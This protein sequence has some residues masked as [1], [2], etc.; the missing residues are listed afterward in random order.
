MRKLMMAA[1]GLMMAMSANAQY[2]NDSKTPFEEGKMYVNAA[3]SSM[4]LSYSKAE[5][6]N[7]GINGKVG[8]FI[9]D[10]LMGV[11]VAGLTS[12]GSGDRTTLQLGAG[13][14][15][16]F[17]TIGIYVGGIA[18]YAYQREKVV[19]DNVKLHS[20]INDFRPELNAGYTFFLNRNIT[21]EPEAYYEISCE[22]S[23]Y[24]GFGLRVGLSIYFNL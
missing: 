9:I 12:E 6:F 2:L 8:Y 5:D 18:K 1:I 13:A 19:I 24:S 21:V 17:D 4:S 16:Y 14:R 15:W 3:F 7:F 20:S 11:G 22:D 10:N 23:D